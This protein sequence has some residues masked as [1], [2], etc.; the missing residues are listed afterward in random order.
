MNYVW[1]CWFAQML[2]QLSSS[3]MAAEWQWSI[4]T[5]LDKHKREGKAWMHK[6]VMYSQKNGGY[7]GISSPGISKKL[8]LSN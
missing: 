4:N 3:L 8:K 2:T 1:T 6:T 5:P 7:C